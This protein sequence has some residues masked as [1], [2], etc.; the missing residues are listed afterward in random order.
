MNM[1]ITRGFGILFVF[2]LRAY[3]LTDYG[4]LCIWDS[5]SDNGSPLEVTLL[6]IGVQSL[7]IRDGTKSPDSRDHEGITAQR[8]VQP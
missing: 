5:A 1:H 8:I 4:V 7:Y 6:L 3:L 2:F